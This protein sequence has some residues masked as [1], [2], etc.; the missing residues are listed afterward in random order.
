MR[1]QRLTRP[2]N[3]L[4]RDIGGRELPAA[5]CT[6]EMKGLVG[7]AVGDLGVNIQHDLICIRI[8]LDG[9]LQRRALCSVRDSGN[10]TSHD[11]PAFGAACL[12][13]SMASLAPARSI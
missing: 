10:S 9:C 3:D 5:G 2:G 4:Q 11:S 1:R 12:R 13:C 6:D 7:N 8:R